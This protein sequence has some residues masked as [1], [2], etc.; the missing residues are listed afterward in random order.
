MADN[1]GE[2]SRRLPKP[3]DNRRFLD[4]TSATMSSRAPSLEQAMLMA[5]VLE[6]QLEKQMEGL[7]LE[8]SLKRML[9]TKSVISTTSS[10]AQRQ[11]AAVGTNVKF[12][13][14]GTGSI[15]KVFEHPGTVFVYKLPVSG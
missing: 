7:P 13:E 4:T 3:S 11:A 5:L 9:S 15:G 1:P 2:G 8:E 6:D 14:I 12:R 10:F